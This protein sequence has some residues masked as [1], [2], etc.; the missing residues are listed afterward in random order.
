MRNSWKPYFKFHS[1][2]S[3]RWED[4]QEQIR[5]KLANSQYQQTI[6]W[7]S[8]ST[9]K[10]IIL[11]IKT[12]IQK[13][14]QIS[15]RI[16]KV[17]RKNTWMNSVALAPFLLLCAFSSK[18]LRI[19]PNPPMRLPVPL[20]SVPLLL[21]LKTSPIL[22]YVLLPKESPPLILKKLSP[23]FPF[24]FLF[25]LFTYLCIYHLPN[26]KSVPER[27][28]PYFLSSFLLILF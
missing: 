1:T 27:K 8:S 13:K 15:V 7:P 18:I 16:P 6:L 2:G 4:D 26:P 25:S 17:T 24:L 20:S 9:P 14:N 11:N 28:I 3:D 10:N 19:S 12:N 21:P 22:Q 23:S 5:G